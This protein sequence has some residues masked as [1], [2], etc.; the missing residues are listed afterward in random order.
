M[1]YNQALTNAG[2]HEFIFGG[3]MSRETEY[4][5]FWEKLGFVPVKEGCFSG[6]KSDTFYGHNAELRSIRLR[7]PGCDTF[8]TGL[9]RLQLWS[10]LRNEGLN[11]VKPLECGSRWMGIYTHD[12]MQLHDSFSANKSMER[13]NLG[14]SPIVNAA[15]Q[16]PPPEHDFDQPFVGLR[17]LLVFGND[18]RLAFIQRAGFDRPGFGTFDDTLAFKN[19]EGSHANIVQPANSFSTEFYKAVLDFDTAPFGEAHDSGD[20]PPTITA[21]D[22]KPG[23]LF[24]IERIRSGDCPSGL[25]QV[26]SSYMEGEDYRDLSRPG[27]RNLCAYSINV[28]DINELKQRLS[29]YGGE[30]LSQTMQDEFGETSVS[31]TAPDGY[32][33]LA[34]SCS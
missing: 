28:S 15:L 10:K 6:E 1:S 14:M 4:L 9:V 25:L 23:E 8:N 2:I 19:T 22:L 11:T 31:F 29:E 26:Y 17:E 27:S 21:L 3:E 30:L 13:W 24:R 12:V 18:F 34:T 20:E 33:W 16:N 7:H 5:E 32:F